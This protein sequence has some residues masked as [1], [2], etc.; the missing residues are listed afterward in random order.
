LKI[1]PARQQKSRLAEIPK[2]FG[3]WGEVFGDD[4]VVA[5]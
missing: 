5:P 2:P 4:V 3:R 1:D